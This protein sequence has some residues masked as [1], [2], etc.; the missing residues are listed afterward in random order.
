MDR[1]QLGAHEA[2]IGS[3]LCCSRDSLP[4]QS[5]RYDT[6]CPCFMTTSLNQLNFI[7][8]VVSAACR[9]CRKNGHFKRGKPWLQNIFFQCRVMVDHLASLAQTDNFTAHFKP[10]F[11]VGIFFY[12]YVSFFN[13]SNSSN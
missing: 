11:A 6:D 4:E 5:T 2:D 8:H 9:T 13:G 12:V 1:A 10:R 7:Q 3:F